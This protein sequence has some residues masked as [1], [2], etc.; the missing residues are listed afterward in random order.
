MDITE[1]RR[2]E[3][4][5]LLNA[6][7]RDGDPYRYIERP[8]RRR[9]VVHTHGY[10]G[11]TPFVLL[12][13]FPGWGE[14]PVPLAKSLA[15]DEN[16]LIAHTRPGYYESTRQPG[17]TLADT[18]DDIDAVTKALGIDAYFIVA[19]SGAGMFA[20]EA[21]ARNK[22]VRGV[23]LLGSMVPPDIMDDS[24]TDGMI[25]AN[26]M[27]KNMTDQQVIDHFRALHR[28]A[29][30][31]N[32]EFSHVPPNLDAQDR[33]DL[34]R[35]GIA[36][37]LQRAYTKSYQQSS[38]ESISGLGWPD[39][40]LAFRRGIKG[41]L[42]A[43]VEQGK[44]NKVLLYYNNDDKYTPWE[45]GW[46]LHELLPGSQYIENYQDYSTNLYNGLIFPHYDSNTHFGGYSDLPDA[47]AMLKHFN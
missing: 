38:I 6:I 17:R 37:S 26:A 11:H 10:K 27:L 1:M 7:D 20:L 12:H 36:T 19:R 9:L 23:A 4:Q 39:D 40:I 46:K 31:E 35:L 32:R 28:L 3:P 34:L 25:S 43:I 14:G 16:F 15:K 22:A 8:G 2:N 13:G 21:L 45:H 5:G 24:W 41:T 33:L 47:T 29:A 30:F 42:N 18:A 44:A